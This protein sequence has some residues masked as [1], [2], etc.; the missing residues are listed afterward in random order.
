MKF[1]T[2]IIST[3]F[4]GSS[5]FLSS[6]KACEKPCQ[7]G[8]SSAFSEKYSQ[9]LTP[10]FDAFKTDIDSTALTGVDMTKFGGNI[11]T[12]INAAIAKT[13]DTIETTFINSLQS[14]AFDAIFNQ[15]PKFK[16][17]CNH[18]KRVTQPPKGVAWQPSDC[19]AMDYI[20]GNPPSI[21]HHLEIVKARVIGTINFELAYNATGT[22]PYIKLFGQAASDAA[23]GAGASASDC[24]TFLVPKVDSNAA[25]SL[26]KLV[27]NVMSTFCVN[28]SCDKYDAEISKLLLSYP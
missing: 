14:F 2:I 15:Q 20:C 11:V 17:D 3:V 8:V 13:A 4:I 23:T 18:P 6:I 25:T 27:Q 7:D 12:A 21:C 5:L 19:V 22:G 10:L 9:E 16:G 26:L 1:T 28:G 24:N